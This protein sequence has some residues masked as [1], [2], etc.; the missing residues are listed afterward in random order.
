[1]KYLKTFEQN[2]AID[3]YWRIDFNS[4]DELVVALEKLGLTSEDNIYN[5]IIHD[6]KEYTDRHVG[7]KYIYIMKA[8]SSM[9][10]DYWYYSTLLPQFKGRAKYMGR[11]KV[12]DYEVNA[13]KYN[14]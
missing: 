11:V 4:I 2:I 5:N 8:I 10:E 1:V 14:L 3:K 7:M 9:N 12:E 13:R 6:Y